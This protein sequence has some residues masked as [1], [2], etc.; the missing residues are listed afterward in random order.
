MKPVESNTH[1]G[2]AGG[3]QQ[4]AIT[5]KQAQKLYSSINLNK[6]N[7]RGVSTGKLNSHMELGSTGN[8][9]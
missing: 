9:T 8:Y 3:S 4:R 7:G 2:P 6:N 1:T 5:P